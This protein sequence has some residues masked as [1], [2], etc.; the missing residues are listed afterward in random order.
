MDLLKA[1]LARKKQLISLTRS[2]EAGASDA[3]DGTA[4][5]TADVNVSPSSGQQLASN[6]GVL[7]P[8]LSDQEIRLRLRVAGLPTCLFAESAEQRAL[9]Y[10]STNAKAAPPALQGISLARPGSKRKREDNVDDDDTIVQP[11]P[12]RQKASVQHEPAAVPP[13]VASSSAPETKEKDRYTHVSAKPFRGQSRTDSRAADKYVYKCFK[14]LLYEWE[15]S[16]IES[17]RGQGGSAT[18]IQQRI[19]GETQENLKPLFK[20]LKD[21]QLPADIRAAAWTW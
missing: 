3:I 14:G 20:L 4:S 10:S 16:V 6:K 5:T 11:E 13:A 12:Q 15:D 2:K 1:E 21:G 19:W 17:T 18:V 9:R 7:V 8:A